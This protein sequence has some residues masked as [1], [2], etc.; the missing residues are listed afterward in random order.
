MHRLKS[1][2]D[3]QNIFAPRRII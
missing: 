1:A 3:P 2:F